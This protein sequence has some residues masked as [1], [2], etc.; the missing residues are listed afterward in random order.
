MSTVR[1]SVQGVFCRRKK[2]GEDGPI[3]KKLSD[4]KLNRGSDAEWMHLKR[5]DDRK[6]SDQATLA[7]RMSGDFDLQHLAGTL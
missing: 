7:N 2:R 5:L 1:F 6:S 4:H 3:G